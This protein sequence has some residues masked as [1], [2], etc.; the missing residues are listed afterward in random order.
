M[1]PLV[2]AKWFLSKLGT[3]FPTLWEIGSLSF[4]MIIFQ[5][6]CFQVSEKTFQGCK[7]FTSQKCRKRIYNC[8]FSKVNAQRKERSGAYHQE[9]ICL[10]FSQAEGKLEAGLVS[11]S[12][13]PHLPVPIMALSL[14]SPLILNITFSKLLSLT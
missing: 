4:W 9:E 8:K 1:I 12:S 11:I 14:L 10:N 3:Y 5:R 2:F 6:D 13:F 7:R